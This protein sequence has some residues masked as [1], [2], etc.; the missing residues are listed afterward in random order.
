MFARGIKML[1]I[2]INKSSATEF[3]AQGN[4]ILPPFT[5]LDGL[6]IEAALSIV[7]ARKQKPFSSILDLQNRTKL[8]TTLIGKLKDLGVL[9]SLEADDQIRLF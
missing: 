7:E 8:S 6:G 3:I 4:S 5:S 1:N 9:D 2:D